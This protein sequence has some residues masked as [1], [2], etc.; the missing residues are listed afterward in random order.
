MPDFSNFSNKNDVNQWLLQQTD[1][2]LQVN[3][4][5]VMAFAANG[6]FGHTE[7]MQLNWFLQKFHDEIQCRMTSPEGYNP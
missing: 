3:L 6:N 5:T 4:D 7:R 2:L 1:T